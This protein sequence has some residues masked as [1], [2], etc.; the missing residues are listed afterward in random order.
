[1]LNLYSY[2][3]MKLGYCFLWMVVIWFVTHLLAFFNLWRNSIT[4][5][6]CKTFPYSSSET[7]IW[8]AKGSFRRA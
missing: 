8:H 2:N 6:P 4:Y 7:V 3:T 1:M 5:V